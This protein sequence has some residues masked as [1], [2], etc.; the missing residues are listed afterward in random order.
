MFLSFLQQAM[1]AKQQ[2]TGICE[3]Y[4]YLADF[5]AMA[6]RYKFH[7]QQSFMGNDKNALTI[8]K[9]NTFSENVMLL[10]RKRNAN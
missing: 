6:E 5:R 3:G 10:F 7:A 8:F 1:K 2:F 9:G 4:Q